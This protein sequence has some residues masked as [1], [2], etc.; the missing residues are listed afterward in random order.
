MGCQGIIKKDRNILNKIFNHGTD[1]KFCDYMSF[2]SSY[3]KPIGA[4]DFTAIE[5]THDKEKFI[6]FKKVMF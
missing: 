3:N 1:C 4:P 6:E 2:G 5:A